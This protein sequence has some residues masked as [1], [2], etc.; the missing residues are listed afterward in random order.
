VTAR[1]GTAPPAAVPELGPSLG[2]VIVPRRRQGLWVPCDD[3][4]E[5]L[6]TAVIELA[7]QGR[8]AAGRGDGTAMLAAT[9]RGAWMAAWDAAV[10][11]VAQRVAQRIDGDLARA[12]RRVRMPQRELRARQLSAAERRAI[13]ARLAAGGGPFVNALDGLDRAAAR[14]REAPTT[15]PPAAWQEALR[16]AARRLEAAW[17]ALETQLQSEAERWAPEIEDVARWRP[18]LA[19][20]FAVWLPLAGVLLWLGLA[21]GG[22]VAV[23]TRLAG[24]LGF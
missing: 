21:Y 1:P 12:A 23:P 14:L 17:L 11:Q 5:T 20:L 9:G 15:A 4:R 7:G 2:R 19:P 8:A 6:A 13:A 18:P 3:I 22:Y 24:W 10:Q 16:A